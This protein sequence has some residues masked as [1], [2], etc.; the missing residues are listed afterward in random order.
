MKT[1]LLVTVEEQS[2]SLWKHRIREQ[3]GETGD[4]DLELTNA[5]WR[6]GVVVVVFHWMAIPALEPA[7]PS[8]LISLLRSGRRD[9]AIT[10][11][12]Y[13]ARLLLREERMQIF[14]PTFFRPKILLVTE[15]SDLFVDVRRN[16]FSCYSRRNIPM[17]YCSQFIVQ[18]I[19]IIGNNCSTEVT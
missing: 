16:W 6:E 14:F 19:I 13:Y 7:L 5:H 15:K 8:R 9:I 12:I 4:V 3:W 18:N 11:G 10:K 1:S 17:I 2:F